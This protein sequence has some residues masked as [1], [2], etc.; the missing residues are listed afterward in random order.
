MLEFT[1][2]AVQVFD[3]VFIGVTKKR[4]KGAK[5]SIILLFTLKFWPKYAYHL[6]KL[7]LILPWK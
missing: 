5:A 2:D 4:T 3:H 1:Q 6:R 7:V